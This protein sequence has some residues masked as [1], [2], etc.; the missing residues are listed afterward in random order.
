MRTE[1]ER[2]P[3][4]VVCILTA[5]YYVQF[6]SV[7]TNDTLQ[8]LLHFSLDTGSAQN[9]IWRSA[10][11]FSSNTFVDTKGAV[12]RLNYYNRK[13]VSLDVMV[14]F[15]G[16]ILK[17]ALRDKVRGGLE[18]ICRIHNPNIFPEIIRSFHWMIVKNK[19]FYFG[20]MCSPNL[21]WEREMQFQIMPGRTQSERCNGFDIDKEKLF[22]GP[23]VKEAPNRS[24]QFKKIVSGKVLLNKW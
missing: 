19:N 22:T 8:K 12:T 21:E 15:F 6:C 3:D 24:P 18:P 14:W 2:S 13:T 10:L 9:T 4:L 5:T 20:N 23:A 17:L 7:G 1:I 11:S 16:L